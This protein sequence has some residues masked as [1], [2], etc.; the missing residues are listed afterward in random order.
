MQLSPFLLFLSYCFSIELHFSFPCPCWRDLVQSTR[1]SA[2]PPRQNS[3]DEKRKLNSPSRRGQLPSRSFLLIRYRF[4]ARCSAD[5][6]RR[7]RRGPLGGRRCLPRSAAVPP[8]SL[9]SLPLIQHSRLLLD[10][11]NSDRDAG[12]PSKTNTSAQR[13]SQQP[14]QAFVYAQGGRRQDGRISEG[15]GGLAVEADGA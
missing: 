7:R 10:N 1:A 12:Q 14:R 13:Q 4:L 6:H 11:N 9:N 5:E 8:R 2:S 15:W 3:A